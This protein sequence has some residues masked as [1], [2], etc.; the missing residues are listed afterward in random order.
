MP[1]YLYAEGNLEEIQTAAKHLENVF[2]EDGFA[3]SNFEIDEDNGLWALSL[4]P[5]EEGVTDTYKIALAELSALSMQ[6]PLKIKELEDEDWVSKSL[7]G[8]SPVEAGRFVVHGSH[9][10]GLNTKGRIPIQI[11]AG[12]AFGTGHHG[13][14]AGCLKIIS[15]EL[16]SYSPCRILDLGTGSGVLAIALAKLLKQEVIATDIDPIS[17][18]T[19]NENIRINGVHPLVKTAVAT[20]FSHSI[21]KEK[22]PFDLIVA[23]ILAGPLCQMAPELAAHTSVGGRIILSGLLPHQRAR[24][25]AAYRTQGMRLIRSITQDGWLVLVL[26]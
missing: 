6:I 18:E 7:E 17:I 26:G 12:Q 13:T 14:T 8:L 15:E 11:N 19:T 1:Q 22:G 23:N 9:D 24:V 4:Y 2:E 3:V 5:A 20:G 10:K 21:F 16:R 25:I